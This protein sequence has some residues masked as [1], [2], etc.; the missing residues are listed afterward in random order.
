MISCGNS[1]RN[2]SFLAFE[3][4]NSANVLDYFYESHFYTTCNGLLSLN[5]ELRRGTIAT[6]DQA[7][8][9]T[10]RVIEW[11]EIIYVNEEGSQG[12]VDESIFVIQKYR[13]QFA[14][15]KQPKEIFY[16]LAGS[17]FES[18]SL[19]RYLENISSTV[20]T[21]FV[22]RF[23]SS[24]SNHRNEIKQVELNPQENQWPSF[25]KFQA[26][27]P[28]SNMNVLQVLKESL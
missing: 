23:T 11:F 17:I 19:G 20:L 15:Q 5:E 4:L 10:T 13:R 22:I 14:A 6:I 25:I 24:L 12:Y 26:N 7:I 21:I 3:G 2:Q 9:N 8:E 18:Q 16:V 27:K 1:Y 28:V